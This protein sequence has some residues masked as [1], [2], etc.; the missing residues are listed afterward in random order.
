MADGGGRAVHRR[1]R[2]VHLGI[3]VAVVAK[4][5]VVV[6]EHEGVG[7]PTAGGRGS[8]RSG[9][10]M[11]EPDGG[12]RLVFAHAD[13]HV[14]A[15]RVVVAGVPRWAV[16]SDTAGGGYDCW[17]VE[18]AGRAGAAERLDGLTAEAARPA[19]EGSLL[20]HVLLGRVDGPVVALEYYCDFCICILTIYNVIASTFRKL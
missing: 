14:V 5:L 2:V 17:R 20:E 18:A 9:R 3:V 15:H 19:A 16:Q 13:W 4:Q 12:C 1:E 10:R 7:R 6:V 11:L 8:R